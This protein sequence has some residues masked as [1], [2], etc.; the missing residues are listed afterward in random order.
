M[1]LVFLS[2]HHICKF[3]HS[4]ASAVASAY[5]VHGIDHRVHC[6]RRACCYS[7][8]RNAFEI[9]NDCSNCTIYAVY[10]I[11]IAEIFG[12]LS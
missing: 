9:I 4:T 1:R 5:I 2:Y 8:V 6:I 12:Y 10:N 11:F 7:A 3:A